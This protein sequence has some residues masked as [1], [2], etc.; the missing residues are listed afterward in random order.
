MMA[1]TMFARTMGKVH[2]IAQ[3]IIE[4]FCYLGAQ[5]HFKYVSKRP[6]LFTIHRLL[7]RVFEMTKIRRGGAD[8]G[9][10]FMR[11]PNEIGTAED[12]RLSSAVPIALPAKIV[13]RLATA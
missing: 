9:I 1:K 6:T 7:V 2:L 4:V 12:T 5:N 3:V 8:N 13:T 11:I 10:T